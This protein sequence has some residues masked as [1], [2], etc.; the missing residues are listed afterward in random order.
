MLVGRAD[1]ARYSHNAPEFKCT[2]G[3]YASKRLDHLRRTQ[4]WQYGNIH[5]EVSLWGTTVEHEG[6]ILVALR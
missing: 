1:A 4:F 5:G 2:C 6:P 3:I